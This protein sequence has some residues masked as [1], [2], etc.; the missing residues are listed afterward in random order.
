MILLPFIATPSITARSSLNVQ[1][2]QLSC[3]TSY[4]FSGLSLMM[5][6]FSSCTCISFC[7]TSWIP[8]MDIY[9][10]KFVIMLTA[11]V[12]SLMCPCSLFGSAMYANLLL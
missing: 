6:F 7:V 1:Y 10:G 8:Q 5:N 9:A 3:G 2:G 11:S 12:L 4:L